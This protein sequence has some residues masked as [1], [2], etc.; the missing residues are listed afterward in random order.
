[1]TTSHT[2]PVTAPPPATSAL[3]PTVPDG[4]SP[5]MQAE[6]AAIND[7]LKQELAK[8]GGDVLKALQRIQRRKSDALINGCGA[9]ITGR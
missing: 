4:L 7:E 5:K 8:T 9:A 1:M 3:I 6:V 2:G